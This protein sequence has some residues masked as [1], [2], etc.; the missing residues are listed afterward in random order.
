MRSKE[1]ILKG[2]TDQSTTSSL[3]HILE[4][5]IDIRDLL[6]PMYKI[7]ATGS[8]TSIKEESDEAKEDEPFKNGQEHKDDER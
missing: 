2:V 8:I 3:K 5:L 6:L 4:V 7:N 1:E